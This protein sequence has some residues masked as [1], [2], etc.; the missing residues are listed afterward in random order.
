MCEYNTIASIGRAKNRQFPRF[1]QQDLRPSHGI[2]ILLKRYYA[3]AV[4]TFT[5]KLP[6]S[7]FFEIAGQARARNISKS[8]V[9]RERLAGHGVHPAAK[10]GHTSLWDRMKDLVIDSGELPRDLSSNKKHLKRYGQNRT[11]R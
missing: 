6:D 7:L 1:G 4:R 11:H 5:V 3:C 2:A 9:V 10:R 8:D